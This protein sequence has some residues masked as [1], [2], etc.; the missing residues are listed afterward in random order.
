MNAVVNHIKIETVSVAVVREDLNHPVIQG[1]KW[2]KLKYNLLAAEQA[3]AAGLLTF[4][5]AYSNHLVA[6]ACAAK[7]AGLDSYGVVRGDELEL[8]PEKWSQT[9]K[10]AQQFGMKLCFV[11]RE[12]YRK[13]EQG[14]KVRSW[15]AD[16]KGEVMVIPE[17]GSNL[18]AV[19]GVAELVD[20]LVAQNIRPTQLFCA[21]GTGGTVAGIIQGV[22]K[23]ALDCQV[24]AV[25]VL[26]G[27][28]GVKNDIN[29]WLCGDVKPDGLRFLTDYHFGGYAN[30]TAELRDFAIEFQQ[31]H[32]IPL[33][34]VYNAK[35]FYALS[36]WIKQGRITASDRPVIINTGGLQGGQF[37]VT[38]ESS[39]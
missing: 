32:H 33:D 3:D 18:L 19:R 15:L 37:G 6:T 2:R 9:L 26:K 17:G 22:T 1:N 10:D 13:K 25:P 14:N 31:Q 5:G 20:E 29:Q 30:W 23:H 24:L 16:L 39:H 7:E 12:A 11:S 38:N 8:Q 21:L 34:K 36:D 35:S 4:G 27:L 28:H